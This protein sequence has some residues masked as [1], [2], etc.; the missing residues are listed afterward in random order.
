MANAAS[1]RVAGLTPGDGYV[2]SFARGL[3]VIRSFSAA[4]PQQTLSGVAARSGL[5]CRQP[6]AQLI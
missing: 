3:E 2:Q 1:T 5:S 6:G 4:A